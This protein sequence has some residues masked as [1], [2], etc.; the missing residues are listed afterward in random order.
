MLMQTLELE[1]QRL[2]YE[3]LDLGGMVEDALLESIGMLKRRDLSGAQRLIALDR[4]IKRRCFFH[5]YL[6]N[7][8]K[9]DV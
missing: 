5:I 1:V 2:Q 9:F 7:A 3:L 6:E 8:Y 4:S